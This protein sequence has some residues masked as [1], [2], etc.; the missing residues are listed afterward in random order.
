MK[1]ISSKPSNMH[2]QILMRCV[3]HNGRKTMM[4]RSRYISTT[5]SRPTSCAGRARRQWST[6]SNTRTDSC[7]LCSSTTSSDAVGMLIKHLLRWWSLY[8][9]TVSNQATRLDMKNT[10]DFTFV[11]LWSVCSRNL[12][13]WL[14]AKGLTWKNCVEFRCC[15]DKT[16]FL[17]QPRNRL[18][19]VSSVIND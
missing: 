5:L 6:T 9:Y 7:G 14:S 2:L 17:L 8:I 4:R 12:R 19:H 3:H 15:P 16:A 10:E 18:L 1:S 13:D 11:V